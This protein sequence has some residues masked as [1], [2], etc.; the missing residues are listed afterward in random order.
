MDNLE[1]TFCI[2]GLMFISINVVFACSVIYTNQRDNN[3]V[4]QR[5][6]F[7]ESVMENLKL[8]EESQ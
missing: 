6:K 8:I 3:Y 1:L 2:I 7:N 4:E 5:R